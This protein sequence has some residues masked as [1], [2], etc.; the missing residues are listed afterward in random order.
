MIPHCRNEQA[1]IRFA[2]HDRRAAF[3]AAQQLL[4][5]IE[6]QA[7]FEFLRLRA[8]AFVTMLD[9]HGPDAR[10]KELDSVPFADFR[11]D[12][13]HGKTA[14]ENGRLH[15]PSSLIRAFRIRTCESSRLSS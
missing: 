11:R 7:T 8:V 10:L 4:A 2:R 12:R 1:L 6:P 14:E 15:G 5:V 13:S 9:Q 3:A